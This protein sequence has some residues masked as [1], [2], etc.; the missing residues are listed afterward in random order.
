M[1]FLP[2]E[3]NSSINDSEYSEANVLCVL[4]QEHLQWLDFFFPTAVVC[5]FSKNAGNSFKSDDKWTLATH[6]LV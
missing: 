6:I 5:Q 3:P 4:I 1:W 2:P